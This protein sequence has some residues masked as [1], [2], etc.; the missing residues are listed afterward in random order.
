MPSVI[1]AFANP[2]RIP[3][4]TA[5][6]DLYPGVLYQK[7]SHRKNNPNISFLTF[8]SS[9]CDFFVVVNSQSGPDKNKIREL[10]KLSLKK[11]QLARM[12]SITR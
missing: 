6:A 8:F 5:A 4:G 2:L 1:T 11:Q 10:L 3:P 12:I 7:Y 9:S